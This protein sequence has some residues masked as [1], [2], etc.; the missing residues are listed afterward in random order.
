MATKLNQIVAVEKGCKQRTH[1]RVTENYQKIQ[2]ADLFN[3]L[4]KSY[5]P[6][7]EEGD[8]LPDESAAVQLNVRDLLKECGAAWA[9]LMDVVLTKEVGNCGAKANV[10]VEIGGTMYSVFKDAP[11]AFLLQAEKLLNDVRTVVSKVP[12]L[13]PTLEWDWDEGARMFRSKPVETHRT[14]K[15]QDF[16]VVAGSGVPEKGVPPVVKDVTK[17]VIAGYWSTTK[18][19]ATLTIAQKREILDRVDALQKAVKQARESANLLEVEQFK[20]G[21]G[22]FDYLFG[23]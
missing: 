10:D 3:G 20:A 14:Q 12:T 4:K 19:S 8:R 16:V 1:D 21:E 15:V 18:L 22:V 7:D 2:K 11:V 5:Q 23:L 6:K 13:D 17:D 9:D